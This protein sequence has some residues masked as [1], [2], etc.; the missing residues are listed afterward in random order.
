[1][2]I[3]STRYN[4]EWKKVKG[5]FEK[6]EQ[7]CPRCKNNVKYSLCFD[8]DEIGLL[9]VLTYKYSKK[10]VY[11]CPICPNFEEVSNELAKAI[12]KGA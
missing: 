11:K 6:E 5:N 9:G 7:I 3:Y 1:M 10:Y 12:I 2:G 8:G 4:F